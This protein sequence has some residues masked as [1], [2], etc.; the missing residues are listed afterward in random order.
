MNGYETSI[1]YIWN[2]RELSSS[3][4]SRAH[5]EQVDGVE[6]YSFR[7]W[8]PNAQAVHLVGDF[9][10]W[11]ENEIPMVRNEA[12]VWEVFITVTQVGDIYKFQ[13]YKT[14]IGQPLDEGGSFSSSHGKTSRNRSGHYRYSREEMERWTLDG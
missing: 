12:G 6:G 13:C 2:R 8:A 9:T 11:E 1:V 7:V 10:Q 5:K 3:T 14:K 4:L